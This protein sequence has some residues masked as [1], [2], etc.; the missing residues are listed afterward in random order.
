MNTNEFRTLIHEAFKSHSIF[1]GR[2]WH[3]L[4]ELL[5]IL[6]SDERFKDFNFN[7]SVESNRHWTCIPALD[8]FVP[9]KLRAVEFYDNEIEFEDDED[10]GVHYHNITIHERK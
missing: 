6:E 4:N 3:S 10:D 9:T 7:I 1:N 8:C 5:Y 2:D